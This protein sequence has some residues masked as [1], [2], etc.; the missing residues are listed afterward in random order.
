MLRFKAWWLFG[1]SENSAFLPLLGRP[2]R[3]SSLTSA[4]GSPRWTRFPFTLG[5]SPTDCALVYVPVMILSLWAQS[6]YSTAPFYTVN[7][8]GFM[9][10]LFWRLTKA[11]YLAL[12][13]HRKNTR[14]SRL[15]PFDFLPECLRSR[16]ESPSTRSSLPQH[17]GRIPLLPSIFYDQVDEIK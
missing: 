3:A 12:H 14:G 8:H 2:H 15:K 9:S 4:P 1:M 10:L 13:S 6:V 16:A 5:T 17:Q 11:G 7:N